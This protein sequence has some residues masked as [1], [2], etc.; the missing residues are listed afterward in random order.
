MTPEQGKAAADMLAT[1][2]EG[3]FPATCAVIAAVKDDNRTYKPDPKSR[4]AWEL[5]AHRMCVDGPGRQEAAC[6]RVGA[7]E[8]TL[9]RP[10]ADLR[11]AR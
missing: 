5:A 10:Q 2:W 9:S 4:T 3:E 1:V 6:H 8:R 7:R 11:R